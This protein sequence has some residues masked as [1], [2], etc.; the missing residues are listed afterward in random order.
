MSHAA[1]Q[2]T[3]R[4]KSK[5]QYMAITRLPRFGRRTSD[6]ILQYGVL[7]RYTDIVVKRLLTPLIGE[8]VFRLISRKSQI[9]G[10]Q[11]LSKK[12]LA[13][14]RLLTGND[15]GSVRPGDVFIV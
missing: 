1:L 6:N 9:P 15:L 4:I 13:L 8:V 14:M 2:L 12:D 11:V 10:P 3:F 5:T 7:I